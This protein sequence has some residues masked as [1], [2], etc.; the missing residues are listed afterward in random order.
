MRGRKT[1]KE[2]SAP[3]L[4]SKISNMPG[5]VPKQFVSQP[6]KAPGLLRLA[7]QK[8]G[9]KQRNRTTPGFENL[10]VARLEHRTGPKLQRRFPRLAKFS[11]AGYTKQQDWKRKL[12]T[13][14][15]VN[16][17][18]AAGNEAGADFIGKRGHEKA[19]RA[20]KVAP[21]R[22][23]V[24]SEV[25]ELVRR[26]QRDPPLVQDY[27]TA[28]MTPGRFDRVQEAII[29]RA[30][31]NFGEAPIP[32]VPKVAIRPKIPRPPRVTPPA[33]SPIFPPASPLTR[34]S[35]S[36][37]EEKMGAMAS[38][39]S[40]PTR[41]DLERAFRFSYPKSRVQA[42]ADAHGIAWKKKDT[43]YD[44][45]EKLL[46]RY[47]EDPDAFLQV[48]LGSGVR[49][50]GKSGPRRK[51]TMDE[52]MAADKLEVALGEVD[53]GNNSKILKNMIANLVQYLYLHKQIDKAMCRD[54]IKRAV[55]SGP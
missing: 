32:H 53:A 1:L 28:L 52:K 31:R 47:D 50:R 49:R 34:S 33:L 7:I 27:E 9:T 25:D 26:F 11:L 55:I 29:R 18:L 19:P 36:G 13:L 35:S 17:A 8:K 16:Q 14:F 23:A 40:P 42:I 41:H 12:G 20:P 21:H 46:A 15:G 2:Q 4:V 5:I 43:Q 39:A 44:I 3:K 24:S 10:K 48:R 37:S 30:I 45:A 51:P 6:G 38:S 22:Q 54:I